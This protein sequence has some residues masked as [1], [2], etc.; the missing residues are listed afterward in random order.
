MKP[1]AERIRPNSLEEFIGQEHLLEK[2][3]TLNKL[4]NAGNIFSMILWEPP[5]CVKT[6]LAKII[7]N[8][9]D[10]EF[11]QVSAISS[12]VREVRK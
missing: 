1:L 9:I 10:A 7:A 12:G 3:K 4:L 11:H 5:G 8:R 2:G 6:T